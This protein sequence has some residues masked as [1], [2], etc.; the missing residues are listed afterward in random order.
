MEHCYD[1]W[2]FLGEKQA[3]LFA[4]ILYAF[5]DGTSIHHIAASPIG[6][7]IGSVITGLIYAIPTFWLASFFRVEF[8]PLVSIAFIVG[9]A[10]SVKIHL[11]KPKPEKSNFKLDVSVKMHDPPQTIQN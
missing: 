6:T 1:Y 3:V 10:A 11:F 5:F 8:R 2:L 7:L 9:A 4:A